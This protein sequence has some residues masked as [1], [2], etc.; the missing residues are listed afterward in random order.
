MERSARRL[1]LCRKVYVL[2]SVTLQEM[3]HADLASFT[4]LNVIHCGVYNT[5]HTKTRKRM[6][7]NM[8]AIS[9]CF[10]A[11]DVERENVCRKNSLI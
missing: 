5:E 6:G 11:F 8:L 7:E 3:T 4:R 2:T 1:Q 10:D 9:R